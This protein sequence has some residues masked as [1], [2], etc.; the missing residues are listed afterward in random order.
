MKTIS[1]RS[2]RRQ[3]EYRMP[4][5]SKGSAVE[6][7]GV[8]DGE[9]ELAALVDAELGRDEPRRAGLPG[10]ED[11]LREGRLR[12]EE[13]DALDRPVR[14]EPV[15]GGEPPTR[16]PPEISGPATE[17]RAEVSGAPSTPVLSNGGGAGLSLTH[18]KR[19]SAE[20]ENR[21]PS[22]A[23]IW[24]EAVPTVASSMSTVASIA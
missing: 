17:H 21:A 11:R 14:R 20:V 13:A 3:I 18:H 8:G 4:G 23:G 7:T 19:Y 1:A 9:P 15:A 6:L 16:L 5:C 22:P 12:E 24:A 2:S 10:R